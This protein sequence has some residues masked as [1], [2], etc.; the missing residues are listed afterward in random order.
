[1]ESK[2]LID[3]CVQKTKIPRISIWDVLRG[4]GRSDHA[5]EFDA[6]K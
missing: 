3:S 6:K 5:V 1:M 4:K 2:D